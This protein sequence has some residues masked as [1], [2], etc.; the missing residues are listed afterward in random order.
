MIQ[1]SFMRALTSAF[2]G[3]RARW[4]DCSSR[5][6]KVLRGRQSQKCS[7]TKDSFI[8]LCLY[9]KLMPDFQ[10]VQRSA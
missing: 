1:M 8:R 5:A 4:Q 7:W 6:Q 10:A 3:T 9:S 2:E